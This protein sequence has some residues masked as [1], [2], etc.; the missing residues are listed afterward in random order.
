M[1]LAKIRKHSILCPELQADV[2]S[3]GVVLWEMLTAELPWTGL[4]AMQVSPRVL[5]RTPY[6][7]AWLAI[8]SSQTAWLRACRR[9][10]L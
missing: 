3:Y 7:I 1:L 6:P 4:N 10:Y 8:A 9:E 2:Y 5:A